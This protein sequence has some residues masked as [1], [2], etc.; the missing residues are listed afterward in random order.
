MKK[1]MMVLAAAAMFGIV[2]C[3]GSESSPAAEFE[4]LVRDI[5]KI[6]HDGKV[7]EAEVKKEVEEFKA[8]SA[9]EQKQALEMARELKKEAP[10][11]KEMTKKAQ[12]DL[13]KISDE[14]K[15]ETDKA[16]ENLK[17]AAENLMKSIGD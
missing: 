4:S 10:K 13:E 2:G 7:N 9:E 3:G 14:I 12:K 6:Q 5:E 15:K 11:L 1:I 16:A 8:M 17:K